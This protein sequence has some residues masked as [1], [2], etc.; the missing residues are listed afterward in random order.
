M[1]AH[2]YA[3]VQGTA[4]PPSRGLRGAPVELLT[5][6]APGIGLLV[7]RV[8]A[9][10]GF[11]AKDV[12]VHHKVVSEAMERFDS[13]VP[14]RF[15]GI[16]AVDRLPGLLRLHREGIAAELSRLAQTVEFTVRWAID[17]NLDPPGDG[18]A[19]SRAGVGE[20]YLARKLAVEERALLRRKATRARERL[21]GLVR[22]ADETELSRP[23]SIELAVS[24]LAERRHSERLQST[25]RAF[26]SEEKGRGDTRFLW[27]GPWPPYG[28]VR[29]RLE[30]GIS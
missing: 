29:L 14:V 6:G 2:A 7:S 19:P 17:R 30:E 9:V 28:F 23:E 1:K 24:F 11:G 25:L 18:G 22:A 27:S 20:R 21:A 10:S 4:P 15:G 3:F 12:Q 13:I 8:Q 5:E 16:H 26:T